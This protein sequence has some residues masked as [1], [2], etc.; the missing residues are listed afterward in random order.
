MTGAPKEGWDTHS[1]S[2]GEALKRGLVIPIL[3]VRMPTPGSVE[4]PAQSIQTRAHLVPEPT[5][6]PQ[7]QAAS[8]VLQQGPC[9]VLLGAFRETITH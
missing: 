5:A 6:L 1:L 8:Q 7:N 4:A 9:V 3:R 2:P